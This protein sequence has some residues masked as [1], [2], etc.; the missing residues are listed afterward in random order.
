M[1]TGCGEGRTPLDILTRKEK[2]RTTNRGGKKGRRIKS[3]Q[4]NS[5]KKGKSRKA[6]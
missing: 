6:Q 5:G 1:K 2:K 3:P 4:K